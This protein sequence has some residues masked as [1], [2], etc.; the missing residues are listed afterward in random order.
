MN[1][2]IS[3]MKVSIFYYDYDEKVRQNRA[4][5]LGCSVVIMVLYLRST[6]LWQ[7]KDLSVDQCTK[8]VVSGVSL[9][10]TG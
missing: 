6:V 9:T 10:L 2:K 4:P 7:D 5:A 8:M 3:R 1:M